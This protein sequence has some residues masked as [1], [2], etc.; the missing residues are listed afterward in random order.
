MPTPQALIH[1]LRAMGPF[2][3]VLQDASMV[4]CQPPDPWPKQNDL[5]QPGLFFSKG[6]RNGE[7]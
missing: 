6:W 7:A 2:A 3:S 4:F 5:F 1:T